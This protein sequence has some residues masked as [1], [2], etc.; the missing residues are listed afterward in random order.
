MRVHCDN[1][2]EGTEYVREMLQQEQGI[3]ELNKKNFKELEVKM[4]QKQTEERQ[5]NPHTDGGPTPR[6]TQ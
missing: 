3:I 4:Y 5:T 6:T 2:H 1:L